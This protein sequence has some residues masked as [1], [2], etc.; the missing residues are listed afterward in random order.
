MKKA[1]SQPT[2]L[3]QFKKEILTNPQQYSKLT[4]SDSK[5]ALYYSKNEH[6][7]IIAV[8]NLLGTKYYRIDLPK[9]PDYTFIK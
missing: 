5:Q 2:Q 7:L 3:S 1:L 8:A 9:H 6:H 4:K